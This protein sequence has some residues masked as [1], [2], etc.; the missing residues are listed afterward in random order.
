MLFDNFNSIISTPERAE[1]SDKTVQMSMSQHK[2]ALV[3]QVRSLKNKKKP[4]VSVID[5]IKHVSNFVES[6]KFQKI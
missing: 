4:T 1:W 6:I 2:S 5:H 3:N